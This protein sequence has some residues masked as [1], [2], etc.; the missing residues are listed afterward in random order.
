MFLPNEK[1]SR[2]FKKFPT[3]VVFYINYPIQIKV[4][5]N[6]RLKFLGERMLK[7]DVLNL[8]KIKINNLCK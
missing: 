1:K 3:E 4:S 6:I 5:I 7:L 8:S 2:F